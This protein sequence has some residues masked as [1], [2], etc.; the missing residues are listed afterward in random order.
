MCVDIIRGQVVPEAD[1]YGR[2]SPGHTL[3]PPQL[4]V[5]RAVRR[6]RLPGRA[7]HRAAEIQPAAE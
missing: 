6:P 3:G 1:C 2:H 4:D 5:W 7:R